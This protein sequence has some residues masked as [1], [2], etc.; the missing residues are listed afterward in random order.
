[1]TNADTAEKIINAEATAF[2]LAT[3]IGSAKGMIQA[4]EMLK[5]AIV[6]ALEHAERV[7]KVHSDID[8]Q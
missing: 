5:E 7:G 3:S 1:M 6:K 4:R 2:A 8:V